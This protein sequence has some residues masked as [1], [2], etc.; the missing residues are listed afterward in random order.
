MQL[1]YRANLTA[2]E[3]PFLS[4]L[5]GRNIIVSNIDQNFSR[6]ASSIKDKDRDVGI[7]QVYYVHNVVPTDAG[8]ASVAYSQIVNPPADS[9]GTF[10]DTFELRDDQGHRAIL[11]VT[12]TGRNYVLVNPTAGWTRTTDKAP[13]AGES[14]TTAY[15]NGKT[16]IYYGKLGCFTYNWTTNALDAVPLT[17]LTAADVKGIVAANGYMIAYTETLIAWSSQIDPT[18]FTPSLVTGAGGGAVQQ[19]KG[20]QVACFEHEVGF[21]IYSQKNIVAAYYSGNAQYPYSFKELVNSGGLATPDNVA[22]NG[23]SNEHYAYTTAGFQTIGKQSSHVAFPQLTD[24]LAGSYFEDFNDTTL[25]FTTTQLATTLRKKIASVSERYL[26]ISYGI[27]TYTHALLYDM[28]LGRWGKLKIDHVDIFEYTIP[29]PGVIEIPKRSVGIL[30]ADGTL[31]L[32]IMSYNTT[33]SQGTVV[34]GKYQLDRQ[35]MLVMD[36]IHLETIKEGSNPTINLLT[37]LDGR[38][39]SVMSPA[40]VLKINRGTY[41]RYDTRHTGLNHSICLQGAFQL[42]SLELRFHDGG[43]VR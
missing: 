31:K 17:S 27:N 22:F 9:D 13:V 41:R 40:P 7:P 38:N 33:G 18:D 28:S 21:M 2:A 30:Q 15:I 10:Y 34:M 4:E 43:Q 26:L 25:Q 37:T 6:Q 11:G 12:T 42:S 19:V 29:D 36:E 5:Q 3:F 8:H 35:N 16:Y 23:N 1:T 39:Y 14:I 24:F 32:C 20:N